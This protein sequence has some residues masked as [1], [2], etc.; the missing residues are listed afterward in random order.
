MILR[1]SEDI[2]HT[3]EENL[4]EPG[5]TRERSARRS[6]TSQNPAPASLTADA[7]DRE[8]ATVHD[9]P[10]KLAQVAPEAR[11]RSSVYRVASLP[12]LQHRSAALV[13][14]RRA[15]ALLDNLAIS[16]DQGI[17]G[18]KVLNA[19]AARH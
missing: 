17:A 4:L 12:G 19:G 6:H 7:P 18:E 9:L 16:P 10:G 8:P 3:M 1:L 5:H 11:E 15:A 2:R 14:F 13:P